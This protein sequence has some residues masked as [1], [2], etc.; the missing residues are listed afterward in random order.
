MAAKEARPDSDIGVLC[1]LRPRRKLGW[2]IGQLADELAG[3]FGLK[4]DLVSLAG[5]SPGAQVRCARRRPLYAA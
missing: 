3:L 5:P 1:S 4:V 2:E